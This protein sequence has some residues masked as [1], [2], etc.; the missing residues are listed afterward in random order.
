MQAPNNAG[1]CS[2]SQ[3]RHQRPWAGRYARGRMKSLEE[4][5]SPPGITGVGR[6]V[7]SGAASANCPG[8]GR[9]NPTTASEAFLVHQVAGA[10]QRW[11]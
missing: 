2:S 9:S 4:A 3:F 10:P 6:T 1:L 11:K 7:P 5:V 8:A